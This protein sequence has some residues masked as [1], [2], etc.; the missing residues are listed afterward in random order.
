MSVFT[1]YSCN[2]F[3]ETNQQLQACYQ[4]NLY[5]ILTWSQA[6]STCQAQGGNLLSITSLAEYRYIRGRCQI[7]QYALLNAA[8]EKS[9]LEY[10]K[11]F[12]VLFFK[13]GDLYLL[14]FVD[15]LASIGAMVWIGL[16]HLKDGWGWQWSDRAPLS[17]VNFTTGR[18]K[19]GPDCFFFIYTFYTDLL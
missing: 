9:R 2:Q 4:F 11:I 13:T 5:T 17:L 3:W 10:D 8:T 19:S 7:R 6:Q 12:N 18:N 1:D 15:R 16:N 14:F